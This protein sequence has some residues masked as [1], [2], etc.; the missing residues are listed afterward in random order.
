MRAPAICKRRPGLALTYKVRDD[1]PAAG[2]ADVWKI[3]GDAGDEVI[4]RVKTRDDT[5]GNQST[6]QPQV[7]LLG[8]DQTTP[9]ADDH[10]S[11][12]GCHPMARWTTP[13]ICSAS[14]SSNTGSTKLTTR[15]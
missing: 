15:C 1:L 5:G 10:P 3:T 9:V 13:A 8:A 7:V 11:V 14:A 12:T 6:L 4:V 2:R